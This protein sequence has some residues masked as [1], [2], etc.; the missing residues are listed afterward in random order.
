MGSKSRKIKRGQKQKRL[1]RLKNRL[2]QGPPQGM[3]VVLEPSGEVKISEVLI[4]FVEPYRE[5]V[6]TEE[7]YRKLIAL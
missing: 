4:D 6:D 1:E 5:S 7:A 3:K 2:E